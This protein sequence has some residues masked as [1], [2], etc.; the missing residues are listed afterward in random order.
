MRVQAIG[1][2][3]KFVQRDGEAVA[4]RHGQ[5][6]PED[7]VSG[8]RIVSIV[9]IPA[10]AVIVTGGSVGAPDTLAVVMLHARHA[11]W[12]IVKHRVQLGDLDGIV[13]K[14]S[15]WKDGPWP[16]D[17]VLSADYDPMLPPEAN[18]A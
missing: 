10:D 3:A 13:V 6:E 15:P 17:S 2:V 14:A 16:G 12:L 9:K 1:D 18:P 7:G 11:G 5:K 4:L 8:T